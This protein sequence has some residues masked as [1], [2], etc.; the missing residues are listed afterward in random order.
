MHMQLQHLGLLLASSETANKLNSKSNSSSSIGDVSTQL[1]GTNY[2][3]F[4]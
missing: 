2:Y 3:F 1:I 4:T